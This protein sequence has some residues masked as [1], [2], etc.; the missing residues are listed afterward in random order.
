MLVP[1]FCNLSGIFAAKSMDWEFSAIEIFCQRFYSQVAIALD[2]FF[3][4]LH[5][6]GS[7]CLLIGP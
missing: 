5:S 1:D 2:L 7:V 6:Q 3:H 4:I